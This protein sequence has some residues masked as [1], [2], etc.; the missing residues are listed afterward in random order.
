MAVAEKTYFPKQVNNYGSC[1]SLSK[2]VSTLMKEAQEK[3]TAQLFL[4]GVAELKN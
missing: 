1:D 3:R 2:S 4:E